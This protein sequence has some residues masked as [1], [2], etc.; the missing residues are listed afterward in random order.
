MLKVFISEHDADY[1]GAVCGHLEK[2]FQ[3]LAEAK[4]WCWDN[5][6]RPYSYL[7][8]LVIDKETNKVV[9]NSRV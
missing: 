2:E 5:S 3:S 9:Y 1:H 8:D 6:E 7:V 4:Q